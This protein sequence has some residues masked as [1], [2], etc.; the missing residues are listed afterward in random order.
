MSDYHTDKNLKMFSKKGIGM[1]VQGSG[2]VQIGIL[3]PEIARKD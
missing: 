1:Y 2:S 3:T